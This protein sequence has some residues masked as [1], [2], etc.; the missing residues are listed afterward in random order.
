M[1]F[2]RPIVDQTK[3]TAYEEGEI[4]RM[5]NPLEDWYWSLV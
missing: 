4:D 2:S 5:F 1:Q 3:K